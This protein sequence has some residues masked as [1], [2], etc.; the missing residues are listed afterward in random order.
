MLTYWLS[1]YVF[2]DYRGKNVQQRVLPLA[3]VLATG[4][5]LLL[6]SLF[7]GR[8]YRTL[9]LILND[10]REGAGYYGITSSTCS[11]FLQVFIWE[12]FKG[13]AMKPVT[14][15]F[16]RK[17]QGVEKSRSVVEFPLCCRWFRRKA[18]KN[19]FEPAIFDDVNKFIFRPYSSILGFQVFPFYYS[20]DQS[21]A[22]PGRTA[23]FLATTLYHIPMYGDRFEPAVTKYSP[24]RVRG[25]FGI[26][27]GV[28]VGGLVCRTAK[29][30][31]V[32]FIKHNENSRKGIFSNCLGTKDSVGIPTLG[33]MKFWGFQLHKFAKFIGTK[34]TMLRRLESPNKNKRLILSKF[35]MGRMSRVNLS[36]VEVYSNG[37]EHMVGYLGRSASRDDSEVTTARVKS[38]N[39]SGS[40]EPITTSKD[41]KKKKKTMR[42]FIILKLRHQ[43]IIPHTQVLE[44]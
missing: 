33:Y 1:K 42:K 34:G 16:L 7:L 25:Q 17:F 5:R 6:A 30:I 14:R 3:V 21:W 29:A 31:I 22:C 18:K 38:G 36:Y 13:L 9:D 27:Q 44:V 11:I 43:K 4:A 23:M 41:G 15:E 12:R 10:E 2:A 39:N 19:A 26:N 35:L 40:R 37:M 24:H 8:F 28:P 20:E 32:S